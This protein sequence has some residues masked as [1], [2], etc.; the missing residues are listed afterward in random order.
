MVK[1]TNGASWLLNWSA[2]LFPRHRLRIIFCMALLIS[3]AVAQVLLLL[4]V[5]ELVHIT[6]MLMEVWAELAAKHTRLVA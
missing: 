3:G 4:M 5:A 2:R 1:W 6:V